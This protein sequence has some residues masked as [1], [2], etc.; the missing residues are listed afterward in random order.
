MIGWM[1]IFRSA[2]PHTSGE[3]YEHFR[4]LWLR[5]L[6]LLRIWLTC[7]GKQY[8]DLTKAFYL[9]ITSVPR[10]CP[11]TILETSKNRLGRSQTLLLA[12]RL[13]F[14]CSP[15]PYSFNVLAFRLNVCNPWTHI[16]VRSRHLRMLSFSSKLAVWASCH[17]SSVGSLKE[18]VR[19]SPPAQ[20]LYG[21]NEKLACAAGQTVN[22]GVQAE[23]LGVF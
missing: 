2:L 13:P 11:K 23:C 4:K 20:S 7:A 14:T 12:S 15:W 3:I 21:M 9:I 22:R 18:S 16:T 19:R 6:L 17:G 8:A 5:S 10:I 1:V